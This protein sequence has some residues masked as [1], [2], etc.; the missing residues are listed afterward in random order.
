MTNYDVAA[1]VSQKGLNDMVTQL[2]A[3]PAAKKGLFAGSKTTPIK[4]LGDVTLSYQVNA[5]PSILLQA[6]KDED[7]AHAE[8]AKPDTPLPTANAVQVTFSDISGT[9]TMAGSDLN[10]Q[11]KLVVIGVV[12][13]N[14]GKVS[15]Q[16]LAVDIDDS[17]FSNW[18]KVIITMLLIPQAI[19]MA[20]KLLSGL[21][22]PKVPEFAGLTFQDLILDVA[23][24]GIVFGTTLTGGAKTELAGFT[25]PSDEGLFA[26]TKLNVLDTLAANNIKPS[27]QTEDSSGGSA[28]KASG[29]VK[30]S[31]IHLA[32]A[33]KDNKFELNVSGSFSAYGELSGTGVGITKAAMCPIGAAADA[34]SDPSGWDKV[35]SSLSLGVKPM[36]LPVPISFSASTPKTDGKQS[37]NVKIDA[38]SIVKK[39]DLTVSPKWSGSVTGSALAAAASAFVDMIPAV[40]ERIVLKEVLA[41]TAPNIAFDLPKISE[42]I[43]LPGG[44][45]VTA[46]ATLETGA[47][48]TPFNG[49]QLL[50]GLSLALS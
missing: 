46:T 27:Y 29:R 33:I 2:Y 4:D 37:I 36:P 23:S 35:V 24:G 13:A 8:K 12:T 21:P 26:L 15:F 22:I 41:K 3:V 30:A 25:F 19:E 6:P 28:F 34:I 39:V 7:W 20:N 9:V 10:A 17:H 40:F 18:D 14:A 42:A 49:D 16:I 48:L 11:G 5:A 38:T 1:G 43:A 50:Q 32:A 47:A 44:A 31:D 45:T